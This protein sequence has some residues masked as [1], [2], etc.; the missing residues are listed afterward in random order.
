MKKLLLAG[1]LSILLVAAVVTVAAARNGNDNGG[2]HLSGELDGFQEVP[3]ISSKAEGE[4]KVK[5]NGSSIRYDLEYSGFTPQNKAQAAHI[6]FAQE[7]VS[8]GIAAFLCGGN[9]SPPCP[10]TSGTVTGT[11]TAANVKAITAQGLAAGDIGSLI[12]A[13][14]AGYTYA[15]VHSATFGSGEIRGQIGD[16]DGDHHGDRGGKRNGDHDDD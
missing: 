5:L 4:I 2:K 16:D 3:S 7:G 9:G 12:R 6:H 1:F 10:E 11:I 13:I 15:N 14:K 8:G